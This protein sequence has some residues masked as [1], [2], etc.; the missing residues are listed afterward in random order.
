MLFIVD[1][2]VH[3]FWCTFECLLGVHILWNH[4][5]CQCLAAQQM[6]TVFGNSLTFALSPRLKCC[7]TSWPACS[8]CHSGGAQGH[9]IMLPVCFPEKEEEHLTICQLAFHLPSFV[10]YILAPCPLF[11]LD[12]QSFY[13]FH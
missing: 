9:P 5:V 7:F 3:V 8:F 12:C 4:C 2:L 1:I 10:K 6:W 11:K 13:F